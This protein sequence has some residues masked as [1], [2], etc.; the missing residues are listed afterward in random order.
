MFAAKP[1]K[2]Y[3]LVAVLALTPRLLLVF[4]YQGI[5]GDT[6]IYET[7]ALNILKNACVSVSSP[8]DGACIPHWGG[9]QLPGYPVFLAAVWS[10]FGKSALAA[11][12]V[13]SVLWTAAACYLVRAV[14]RFTGKW[15]AALLVGV[16][17]A[18]S[19]LQIPWVRMTL[20]ETSA[21]TTTLWVFAEL[22]L[23][24]ADRRL[25]AVPLGIAL[26]AAIF[27]RY[28]Q[29]FLCLAVA[30]VGFYLYTPVQALKRGLVIALVVAAP[31]MAW[32][33]RNMVVGLDVVPHALTLEDGGVPPLGYIAW[34]N[35][36]TTN[37]YQ[38]PA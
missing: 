33:A 4:F 26:A 29:I 35:T 9:N 8:V 25:R 7:V 2:L 12:V 27:V 17:L 23:S 14:W 16:V 6:A 38:Y 5:G 34:G 1:W 32:T 3:A 15:S 30:A 22:I 24:L 13:Q 10:V 28:D 20:T 18:L 19:P 37:Q 11:N 36:W 31:L 21:F